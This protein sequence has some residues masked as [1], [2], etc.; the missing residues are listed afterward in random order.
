MTSAP[1]GIHGARPGPL[2]VFRLQSPETR[3]TLALTWLVLLSIVG[4]AV[5]ADQ[6][7]PGLDAVRVWGR[8]ASEFTCVVLL[9]WVQLA[10]SRGGAHLRRPWVV[11]VLVA[12]SALPSL[13]GVLMFGL[14]PAGAAVV[15]SYRGTTRLIGCLVVAGVL[16]MALPRPTPFFFVGYVAE[17]AL[18]V[19]IIVAATVLAIR[20][21]QI[22][23][24]R[25]VLARRRVDVER[26]R[27]ARDLHDLMGRTL[28]AAS[29]RNQT[30]LRLIGESR[31][32][33]LEELERNHEILARGQAQLRALA[34]GPAMTDLEGELAAA[35]SLCERVGITTRVDLRADPPGSMDPILGILVRETVTHVLKHSTAS[36]CSITI[37]AEGD[38]IS[39][40]VANDGVPTG[41]ARSDLGPTDS[42]LTRSVEA[43]GGRVSHQ[44]LEGGTYA[45][46]VLLPVTRHTRGVVPR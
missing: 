27:I 44:V 25:E 45:L 1:A 20:L 26:D 4:G 29:L 46:R 7:T 35:E 12:V 8:A 43:C 32:P 22:H 14:I 31:R 2:T 13:S 5:L 6:R 16:A 15:I 23:L 21:D 39:V 34:S 11:P 18:Y 41:R 24:T 9:A 30:A 40:T 38:E 33:I 17:S 3:V 19:A 42:R 36:W 10:A 28:V 37:D